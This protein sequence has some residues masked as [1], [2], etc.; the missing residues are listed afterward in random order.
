MNLKFDIWPWKTIAH[1]FYTTSS[2][3]HHSKAVGEFKLELQSGNAEFGS[4]LA[5]FSLVWPWNLMYGLEKQDDTS[6]LLRQDL[7]II[8][9]PS[10]YSTWTYSPE[11]LNSA[12]NRRFFIPCDLQIWQ[13]TL[14]NNRAPLL[15]FVLHLIAIWQFKLELQSETLY[16][17]QNRW[18]FCPAWPWNLTWPW[19][20]I[21][22]IS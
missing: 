5:I 10:V 8:S 14:K 1:L 15:R 17:G 11:S 12:Q 18:F 16:L 22:H 2:F 3:M 19:K 4:K 9:K 21:G 13:M 6:S 7:C 20:T